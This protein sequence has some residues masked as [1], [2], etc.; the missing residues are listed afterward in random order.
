ML[1]NN[2]YSDTMMTRNHGDEKSQRGGLNGKHRTARKE[3]C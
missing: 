3:D 2:L 1:T